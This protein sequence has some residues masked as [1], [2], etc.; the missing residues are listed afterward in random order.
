MT[1]AEARSGWCTET[2]TAPPHPWAIP[3]EDPERPALTAQPSDPAVPSI[4]FA[5][6]GCVPSAGTCKPHAC[7]QYIC[8]Q[9][10]GAL[11]TLHLCPRLASFRKV[12]WFTEFK[13]IL[14]LAAPNIVQGAAQ[15]AMAMTDLLFLGHLGTSSLAAASLGNTYSNLMWWVWWVREVLPHSLP[16][17]LTPGTKPQSCT[18]NP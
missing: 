9:P 14:K 5:N 10:Q 18:P 16:E 17:A 6:E 2:H 8:M 12:S 1:S 11:P 3:M 7:L 4:V 13:V 15:Q